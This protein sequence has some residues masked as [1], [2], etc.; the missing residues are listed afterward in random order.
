MRREEASVRTLYARFEPIE[1]T[2]MPH[3]SASAPP[4]KSFS[5]NLE[6]S[7]LIA[8]EKD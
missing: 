2:A 4:P 5:L 8:F 7:G 1:K 3:L 6:R